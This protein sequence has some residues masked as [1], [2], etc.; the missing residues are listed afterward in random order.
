MAIVET[1]TRRELDHGHI[2][3][4]VT[5]MLIGSVRESVVD[6]YD[7]GLSLAKSLVFC[8]QLGSCLV[9]E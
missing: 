7:L 6:F 3:Y 5:K 9:L 1:L 8:S 4:F 2:R